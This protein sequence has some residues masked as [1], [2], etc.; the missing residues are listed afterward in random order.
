MKSRHER[1]LY[2]PNILP[3]IIYHVVDRLVDIVIA[4][5]EI[6]VSKDRVHGAGLI[7]L[8]PYSRVMLIE[9]QIFF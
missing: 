6:Y 1:V 7:N 2:L 3:K 9:L 5:L 8:W 4:P